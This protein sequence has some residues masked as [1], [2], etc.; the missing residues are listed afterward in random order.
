MIVYCVHLGALLSL[1]LVMGGRLPQTS[2]K[3][4]ECVST[5]DYSE[6]FQLSKSKLLTKS[7]YQVFHA[8]SLLNQLV[9][10]HK[11]L[12]FPDDSSQGVEDSKARYLLVEAKVASFERDCFGLH[13]RLDEDSSFL[14][15]VKH[16]GTSV[17]LVGRIME[18][19]KLLDEKK[20][21]VSQLKHK[22]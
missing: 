6:V 1:P 7:T 19:E 3:I 9:V 16:C 5:Y 14:E 18:L 12:L 11:E 17:T 4:K 22:L 21:G 13:D 2:A 10:D 8:V 15:E 20:H